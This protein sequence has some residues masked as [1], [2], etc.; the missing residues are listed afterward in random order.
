M[1][2]VPR[3]VVA[4]VAALLLGGG[5][6]ACSGSDD[7]PEADP[8]VSATPLSAYDA[9]GVAIARAD[10]CDRIPD[11]AVEAAI[12]KVDDTTHY[13][14]GDTATITGD[15]EDVAHEFNCTFRGTSGAQARVWVF[16]PTVTK[17]RAK[18]LVADAR[19]ARGCRGVDGQGF[20][21]P[22]T[23]V[24]CRTKAGTEAS[25]RGLFVDAWLA[26]SVSDPDRKT[27]AGPAL[28]KAGNWCVQ[29]ASA[30]ASE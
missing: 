17:A 20:G 22:S 29:A 25:Y 2:T 16:V 27:P 7:E 30:A 6:A 21:T 1:R 18:A 28:E 15:V 3:P 14:N 24:L 8:T 26:C 4:V 19:S 12:G 23:G 9:T 11:A 13:G 5:L 10:F